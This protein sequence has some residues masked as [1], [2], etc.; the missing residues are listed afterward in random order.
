MIDW[1][2]NSLI[3][4]SQLIQYSSNTVKE[5]NAGKK[6]KCGSEKSSKRFLALRK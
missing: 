4:W 6:K 3:D 5:K 2:L 1:F